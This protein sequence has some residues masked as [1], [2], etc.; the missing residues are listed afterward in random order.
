[1]GPPREL[2][3]PGRRRYRAFRSVVAARAE[4]LGVAADALLQAECVASA[5]LGR[6]VSAADVADAVTF[7][8]GAEAAAITGEHI[9]VD[10]GRS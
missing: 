6:L 8:A 7:L 10:A 2:G 9:L 5:A 3:L 1:M 4:S